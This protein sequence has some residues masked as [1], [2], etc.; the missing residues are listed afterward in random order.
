MLVL[1]DL[2]A[3]LQHKRLP[4][5]D[6]LEL[7]PQGVCLGRLLDRSLGGQAARLRRPGEEKH[8]VEAL[9]GVHCAESLHH[10]P[11]HLEV[12]ILDDG[13][14][15]ELV[16]CEIPSS[17]SDAGPAKGT[18]LSHCLRKEG[19]ASVN[20]RLYEIAVISRRA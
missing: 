6:L 18:T 16:H 14:E 3:R 8:A 5:E 1:E 20:R 19:E 10:R 11:G 15:E 13:S 7:P 17:S 2:V 9:P 4:R 12:A